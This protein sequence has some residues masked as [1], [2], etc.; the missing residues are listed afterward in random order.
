[1]TAA[2]MH[3]MHSLAELADTLATLPVGDTLVAV[4][5][6][7]EGHYLFI[8]DTLAHHLWAVTTRE[9]QCLQALLNAMTV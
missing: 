6:C 2:T 8:G 7:E 5:G 4:V 9:L 1:M 3:H